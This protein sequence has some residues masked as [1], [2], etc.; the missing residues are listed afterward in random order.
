MVGFVHKNLRELWIDPYDYQQQLLEATWTLALS[1]MRVWIYNHQLC[2][3]DRR[4]WGFSRKSISDWKNIYL[5]QC[6]DCDV[7]TEC[8]ASSS[9]RRRSTAHIFNQSFK[10]SVRTE[11][12]GRRLIVRKIR[13]S[14][15]LH[16]CDGPPRRSSMQRAARQCWMLAVAG[17]QMQFGLPSSAPP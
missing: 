3:L 13:R 4:L 15:P 16:S 9:R 12:Y 17:A 5:E 2:V 10:P 6:N 1:G 11:E 8:G 14:L 7:K